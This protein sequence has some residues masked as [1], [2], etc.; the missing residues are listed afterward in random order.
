MPVRGQI[1]WSQG[2]LREITRAASTGRLRP[3]ARPTCVIRGSGA[4]WGS[5]PASPGP[6][7]CVQAQLDI[8]RRL[9][10]TLQRAVRLGEPRLVHTVCATQWN[11]CL[12]LLQHNLRHHLR[13]PLT[14]LAD[15]LEKADRWRPGLSPGGARGAEAQGRDEIQLIFPERGQE[16]TA[17]PRGGGSRGRRPFGRCPGAQGQGPAGQTGTPRWHPPELERGQGERASSGGFW[18]AGRVTAVG[19]GA[20]GAGAGGEGWDG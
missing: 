19:T 2:P 14:S 16:P 12:P 20:V 1:Q 7:C 13:K 9:D 4:G 6:L 11:T 8:V 18:A 10:A 15:V 5:P 3:G 17:S